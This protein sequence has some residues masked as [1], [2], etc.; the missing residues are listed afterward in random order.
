MRSTDSTGGIAAAIFDLDGVVTL[1]AR[2]HAAAWKDVFDDYLLSREQRFGERFRP[3][4]ILDYR[5]YVDG[6][7]RM[8]GIRSFL[9]SRGITLPDD[10]NR[11]T[12]QDTITSLSDRKN[13]RFVKLVRERG[14]DVDADAVEF[15]RALKYNGVRVG[16]ASSSR[17]TR[18]ILELVGLNTLFDALIDGVVSEEMRLR[19]KPEPDIFLACL[20]ALGIPD[21]QRAVVIEDAVSGVQAGHAAGFAIVIGVDRVGST[22][23][24]EHGADW[25]IRSFRELSPARVNEYYTH[26]PHAK[27]NAIA[28]FDRFISEMNDRGLAL[29]L[30]YDGTLTP[31]VSRPDLAT[32]SDGMRVALRRV[33]DAWPT[34]IVSGRGREDVTGLVGLDTINYAGSH[35]FD[36][37][38]PGLGRNSHD[39]A[40]EIQPV[41]RSAAIELWSQTSGIPGVIVEDKKYS[42]AVHYR[43]V[44][45]DR[46]REVEDLV[47]QVLHTK[48]QLRKAFGKKVFELRP[49]INWDKGRAIR[50]ILNA[51]GLDRANVMTIYIGDDVTDED[52][53]VAVKDCGAG[54]LVT[55]IPRPTAATFSLQDVTEVK[56]LLERLANRK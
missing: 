41:V 24:R 5:K 31:I 50:W 32:L 47:D 2:V 40:P 34:T 13:E 25:V 52:A 11:K 55:D 21:P 14:V 18:L 44:A 20:D 16:V 15:I 30:D 10:N 8:D 46:V 9:A 28:N 17:N 42:V 6:R 4:T 54:I 39:V 23:L 7:P 27:P 19:G 1:T 35:G 53:F 49:T 29:F 38:G 33:S 22:T 51:L 48:P 12:D 45:E 56:A 26:L 36:I 37:A 3:F 43:L